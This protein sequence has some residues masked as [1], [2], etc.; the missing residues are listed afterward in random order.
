MLYNP[1]IQNESSCFGYH[2]ILFPTINA[3]H[4]QTMHN[5]SLTSIL[6]SSLFYDIGSTY[7]NYA[8]ILSS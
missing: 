1:I 2:S 8:P 3:L 5:L 7:S 6:S 4:H